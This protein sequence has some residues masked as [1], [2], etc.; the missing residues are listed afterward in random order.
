MSLIEESEPKQVRM[1]H[2]AIVGSHSVNGVSALHSE[3]IR[4][5]LVPDFSALWP[6]RFNNKT[7]GI[8][9][10]RWLLKANPKLAALITQTI[11]TGWVTELSQLRG[12][13]RVSADATFQAQFRAI[14]RANKERLA[15]VIQRSTQLVVDPGSLFDVQVKRIHGYKRQL[16]K[17]MHIV[18]EYL[19]L[20]EAQNAPPCPEP[21]SSLARRRRATGRRSRSSSSFT[22]WLAPIN[23]DARARDWIKVVFL[24]DY[25]V[26]L[27]EQII[28]AADLSE[29]ISTAG[30]EASGTSNMKFALN[31]AITIG[32]LDGANIEILE[33]V[34]AENIFMFGLSARDVQLLSQQA[35]YRPHDYYERDVRVRRTTDALGSS[36]FCKEEPEL[37]AWIKRVLLDPA[38]QYVHLADL[39]EYLDAHDRVSAAWLEQERWTRMAILNVARTGKFS[40]DRTIAEYA[41]EIWDLKG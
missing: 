12:L 41:R 9:P 19:A 39:A 26:T 11:G 34:G 15:A 29:Q 24:P 25:R 14:K 7:N 10:R 33:E 28:P 32:T 1:A 38:D 21:T 37:F 30:N 5:K 17:V 8:T 6:E 23:T 2:L 20:I 40:S 18:H 27:A 31:G 35:S 22:R 16:L 4:S 3:L 13:A 36:L